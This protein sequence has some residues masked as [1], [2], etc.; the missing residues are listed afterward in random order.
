MR[1]WAYMNNEVL[2]PFEK[3]KLAKLP[4]FTGA[5][6][7]CPETPAGGQTPDW[8]EA[9]TYPEVSAALA[10]PGQA[11]VPVP[12]KT[13]PA[14]TESPLAMTMRGS[15]IEPAAEPLA[16]AVAPPKA[17]VVTPVP[18][19]ATTK[20]PA[21]SPLL[22][23]MRGSLIEPVVTEPAAAASAAFSLEPIPALKPAVI[24]SPKETPQT[25][26]PAKA[27]AMSENI[28][29]SREL[30]S[31]PEA[32]KQQLEQISTMLVSVGDNQIQLL[33]RLSRL[34]SAVAEIRTLLSSE[35]PK[36]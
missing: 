36:K 5:S 34:E 12:V 7:I 14:E 15:L 21:E 35:L 26:V 20:R 25:V 31:Q 23:T 24:E 30:N 2:G 27:Q 13:R 17:A 29:A 18:A 11:P 4:N 33:G 8:K 1:Y 3:E 10:S 28:P 6:L 22:M 32:L 9:S 16:P 19:P